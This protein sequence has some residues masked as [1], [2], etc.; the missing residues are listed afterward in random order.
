MA[1]MSRSGTP[2]NSS[3]ISS[4]FGT[5]LLRRLPVSCSRRSA[6]S[7]LTFSTNTVSEWSTFSGSS[8]PSS[9]R[10]S[11]TRRRTEVSATEKALRRR[12]CMGA[13]DHAAEPSTT[14]KGRQKI[15][16]IEQFETWS[17]KAPITTLQIM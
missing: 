12:R 14:Q 1:I 4:A 9:P 16:A 17:V 5:T 10:S 6:I 7:I 15:G 8:G 3:S 13:N 2:R 11:L